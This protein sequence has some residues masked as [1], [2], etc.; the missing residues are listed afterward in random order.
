MKHHNTTSC[1]IGNIIIQLPVIHVQ[2]PVTTGQVTHEASLSKQQICH[3]TQLAS[4]PGLAHSSLAI[5]YSRILYTSNEHARPGNKATHTTV[6]HCPLSHDN[7]IN[8]PNLM[9]EVNCYIIIGPYHILR[10]GKS[11]KKNF[12]HQIISGTHGI[13]RRRVKI[14]GH[15]LLHNFIGYSETAHGRVLYGFTVCNR[16]P[17]F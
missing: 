4:F 9:I 15:C 7:I 6:C 13:G 17:L 2:L 3:G 5:R 10:I 1:S 12:V 14:H 11:K 8:K 16:T